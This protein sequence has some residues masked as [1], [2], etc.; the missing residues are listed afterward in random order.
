M[1][2]K[3]TRKVVKGRNQNKNRR[4]TREEKK[5]TGEKKAALTLLGGG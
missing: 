4:P 5:I 3:F 1:V 2:I